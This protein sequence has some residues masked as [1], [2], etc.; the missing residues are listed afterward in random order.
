MAEND[1][2]SNTPYGSPDFKQ[3]DLI[4]EYLTHLA[5]F[6]SGE[7]FA[8][9]GATPQFGMTKSEP[10]AT[11]STSGVS[12][13]SAG[14]E[15]MAKAIRELVDVLR[16]FA[17]QKSQEPQQATSP[18][19]EAATVQQPQQPQPVGQ[20][21]Q[22]QEPQQGFDAADV[23]EQPRQRQVETILGPEQVPSVTE[24]D[25]ALPS[26]PAIPELPEIPSPSFQIPVEPVEESP[27]GSVFSP[28]DIE[29]VPTIS[30]LPS[31]NGRRSF[32]FED[33]VPVDEIG[34]AGNSL[35]GGRVPHT[36]DQ[37]TQGTDVAT[38]YAE[39]MET[40][41]AAMKDVHHRIISILQG[42]VMD[43]RNDNSRL[44]EIER[45]FRQQRETL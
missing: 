38:D 2:S 5:K 8:A 36:V 32:R 35:Y 19:A 11:D 4:R 44:E 20:D 13:V 1:N 42:I 31:R 33:F 28:P 29:G 40:F 23:L 6:V 39:T 27:D 30:D 17:T 18:S 41:R 14:F 21:V 22:V 26:E 12:S 10:G 3:N 25:P 34:G 15:E 37:A 24:P 43:M 45:Y 7:P 16:G 9:G